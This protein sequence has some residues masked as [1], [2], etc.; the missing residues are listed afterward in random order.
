PQCR[1]QGWGS[2]FLKAWTLR[3]LKED[4]EIEFFSLEVSELN[5][6]ALHF[7]LSLGFEVLR[8]REKY[9]RDSSSAL[10]MELSK[11]KILAM[12]STC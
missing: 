2:R 3:M 9:Y 5:S 10:V 7:Y 11:R 12:T 6:E 4:P 1:G 8:V